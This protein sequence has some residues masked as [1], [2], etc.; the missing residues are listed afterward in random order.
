MTVFF[1]SDTHFAHRNI[2]RYCARP[3]TSAEEM[4]AAMIANW[5]A[6]VGADD[7]VY[8]LGDFSWS[9][10][11][12]RLRAL[13]DQLPGR[14]HLVIGNHDRGDVQALPWAS[15]P[16][17]YRRIQVGDRAVVLSHY[18]LRVWE[19]M[20]HGAVHLYGHS[21]GALPGFR[22]QWGGGCCDVGVDCWGFAPI[23]LDTIL[24]QVDTFSVHLPETAAD[25]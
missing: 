19:L 6:V 20:R 16:T 18:G 22:T 8:H 21:H 9:M 7:E 3:Y 1:T 11:R 10:G 23:S 2:L 24:A 15:P 13:F 17:H 12:G 25:V 14:K 5:Q 4:D